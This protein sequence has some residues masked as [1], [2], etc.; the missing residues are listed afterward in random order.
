MED[1]KIR[2]KPI[3][4]PIAEAGLWGEAVRE[5]K[6][7][8]VNDYKGDHPGKKGIPEGH[9]SL[10]RILVVPGFSHGRIVVLAA[11]ADKPTDYTEEDHE[12]INAFITHLQVILERKQAEEDLRESENRLP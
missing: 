2:D 12:Q 9:V 6:I 10:T 8:I 1:R 5:R 3:E 11:V 7:L 4:F